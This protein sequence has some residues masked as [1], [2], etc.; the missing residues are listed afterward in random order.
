M[1]LEIN[2][3]TLFE[4]LIL[5]LSEEEGNLYFQV[6]FDEFNVNEESCLEIHTLKDSVTY[7]MQ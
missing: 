4:K 1:L 2:E 7:Q 3:K 6:A 5:I